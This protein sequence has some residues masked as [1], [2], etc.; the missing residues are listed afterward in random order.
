LKDNGFTL[1]QML[2]DPPRLMELLIAITTYDKD[3]TLF[4]R[5]MHG[6]MNIAYLCKRNRSRTWGKDG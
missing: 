2:Y 5:T 4:A 1:H 6:V 3:V